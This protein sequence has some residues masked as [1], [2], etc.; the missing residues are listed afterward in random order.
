MLVWKN[1]MLW[2]V[3]L[4]ATALAASILGIWSLLGDVP[5]ITHI[6][7]TRDWTS[8][9]P[10]PVSRWWDVALVPVW[11]FL[12]TWRSLL[13]VPQEE[14]EGGND[15]IAGI[16]F[17]FIAAVVVG[18]AFGLE[19]AICAF[20]F[21]GFLAGL[22]VDDW[23]IG[24]WVSAI[25]GII[26]DLIIGPVGLFCGLLYFGLIVCIKF[27]LSSRFWAETRVWLSGQN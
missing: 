27:A 23:A 11:A 18:R 8:Q 14:H 12:L 7:M 16:A 6:K 21:F 25:L 4:F 17:G 26:S 1:K 20:V 19:A 22:V 5:V 9:L 10:F 24:A 3:P 2:R 13:A 15:L